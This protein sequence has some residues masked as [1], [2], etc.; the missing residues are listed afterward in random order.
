MKFGLTWIRSAADTAFYSRVEMRVLIL[1]DTLG[2]P[3]L[4]QPWLQELEKAVEIVVAGSLNEVLANTRSGMV[5]LGGRFLNATREIRQA[6][7]GAY[8]VGRL[9]WS[10]VG[11]RAFYPWGDEL[12]EPT[13][14]I[15]V[16][17][18]DWLNKGISSAPLNSPWVFLAGDVERI[19]EALP[20]AVVM[21][22][23]ERRILAANRAALALFGYGRDELIGKEIEIL[24]P[25]RVAA[26]HPELYRNFTR[27]P[28]T[29]AMG[30][31]RDLAARKKGGEEFPVEVGLTLLN[32]EP[33]FYLASIVDLTL[34]KRAE[35][36]LRDRQSLLESSLQEVRQQLEEQVAAS[37]RLEERQRLGREL[38]D[39]LS[40]N[41]Y[42]IG[43]GLKTALAKLDKG[44][45]PL[46]PLKYCLTLTDSAL[47]EMRALLFKLRPASLEDVPLADVL[48]S[49]AQAVGARTK[50]EVVFEHI[51][52]WHEEL[53]FDGKYALY[54][55]ATE[56]LHNCTKHAQDATRVSI[57]LSSQPD[58][59][60]LK[61]LDDGP[62]FSQEAV[63]C[64][65]GMRTM[66]ERAE[67]AR[68]T[69]DVQTGPA[70]TEVV[71]LLPRTRTASGGPGKEA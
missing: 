38:H 5:I 36:M 23:H 25:E 16:L 2:V 20:V 32:T 55:I 4:V 27:D 29:R 8:I 64:G 69:L 61:V 57:T 60:V 43:L 33:G 14:D 22:D 34:R 48:A 7:P 66:R 65:H 39:T 28:S 56:A 24:L 37:T 49:H 21:A 17:I 52:N 31:G 12:R 15:G 13:L 42:G 68:G 1:D 30:T 63:S 9:P 35:E 54:R 53:D 44:G 47:V 26:R 58:R 70:G 41:L 11:P 71:A 62:G 40:Q 10:D 67:A 51:K 46:D 19:V 6:H 59:V 45:D 18:R 50:F 3:R